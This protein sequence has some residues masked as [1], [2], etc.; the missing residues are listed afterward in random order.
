MVSEIAHAVAPGFQIRLSSSL[1]RSILCIS[2]T[3][4][5]APLAGFRDFLQEDSSS[6]LPEGH[7]D[8][9]REPAEPPAP[10]SF[11]KSAC[12][13]VQGQEVRC[14]AAPRARLPPGFLPCLMR[15]R[16]P[17]RKVRGDLRDNVPE[18]GR[19]LSSVPF[20][21]V[22]IFSGRGTGTSRKLLP[23]KMQ[24]P[25]FVIRRQALPAPYGRRHPLPV[26]ASPS[27]SFSP[28]GYPF[29]P[30]PYIPPP[31]Q[32]HGGSDGDATHR[33][34]FPPVTVPG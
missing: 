19:S 25:A 20:P 9:G 30:L 8:S 14:A 6:G 15:N 26:R 32:G 4:C 16:D 1:S 33:T 29:F 23:S 24:S 31:W 34:E 21:F 28:Q 2:P 17:A 10:S 5:V 13:G 12:S 22:I 3:A 7:R 18:G 11:R 27:P